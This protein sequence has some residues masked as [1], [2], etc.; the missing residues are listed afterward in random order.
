M[1]FL[2]FA[3]PM[4][5]QFIEDTNPKQLCTYLGACTSLLAASGAHPPALP[6]D[7]ILQLSTSRAKIEAL[8]PSND[9][10]DACKVR[11][12]LNPEAI[13]ISSCSRFLMI[14]FPEKEFHGPRNLDLLSL[15]AF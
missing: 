14:S 1:L 10:C 12:S 2:P 13:N 3:E 5:S 11:G 15:Q 4:V 8:I 6:V 9:N 7:F